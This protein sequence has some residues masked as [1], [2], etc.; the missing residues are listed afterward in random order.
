[1]GRDI[2]EMF[3]FLQKRKQRKEICGEKKFR[4][5]EICFKAIDCGCCDYYQFMYCI[6][7]ARL[8]REKQAEKRMAQFKFNKKQLSK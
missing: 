6:A 2:G 1:M 5:R 8:E 3:K 4:S 7:A